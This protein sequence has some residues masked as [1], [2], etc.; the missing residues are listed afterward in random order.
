[1]ADV[2]KKKLWEFFARYENVITQPQYNKNKNTPL[3]EL[4]SGRMIICHKE[5]RSYYSP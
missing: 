5:I 3:L 1:M 4:T 2:E